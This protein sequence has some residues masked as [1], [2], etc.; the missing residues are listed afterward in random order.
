[1]HFRYG[2]LEVRARVPFRH[3]AWPSFWLTGSKRERTMP[4]YP[5]ADVFEVFSSTNT[6]VSTI[7]KWQPPGKH[8]AL[9]A[10]KKTK[11]SDYRFADCSKL[12]DE[13]H[14][15]GFEWTPT[16]MKFYVD[17][18]LHLTMF[19][20]AEHDFA[21]PDGSLSGLE[22][23]RDPMG[24][25][26]N[27]EVFTPGHGWCPKAYACTPEDPL[28]IE[29]WIDWVRLWQRPNSDETIVYDKAKESVAGNPVK[30]MVF[31]DLH[32]VDCFPNGDFA[33]LDE[34]IRQAKA[35]GC[36]FMVHLGDLV[37]NV[38]DPM[39]R[40]CVRR[41][42]ECGIP[43]YHVMGNHDMDLT[44][45]KEVVKA[46]GMPDV[47]YF[48]DRG[49]FRFIVLDANYARTADG[50]YAHFERGHPSWKVK[51]GEVNDWIPPEQAGYPKHER[52]GRPVHPKIQ[53]A[54]L[55]LG[56]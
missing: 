41:Y 24:I 3:G 18:T 2:Y 7:H 55:K 44:S 47:H 56:F 4:W 54:D 17:G 8:V 23:F 5:E 53:S 51:P 10:S 50:R 19:L 42:N 40:E 35:Q 28:P 30:F 36:E 26:I 13:F 21:L 6:V 46:F 39:Q 31:A 14:T 15:Y 16:T 11:G 9:T 25:N 49:G 48:F 1:M 45:C 12:N 32:C 43:A 27:N 33:F 34:I 52:D 22:G 37:N 29:Y 38:S 20:D